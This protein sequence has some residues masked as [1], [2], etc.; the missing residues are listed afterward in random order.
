MRVFEQIWQKIGF[1]RA[2]FSVY[3]QDRGFW[4]YTGKI[5]IKLLCRLG[6][7]DYY[8]YFKRGNMTALTKSERVKSFKGFQKSNHSQSFQWFVYI[9]TFLYLCW[10]M[11]LNFNFQRT[12]IKAKYN[13]LEYIII[14]CVKYFRIGSR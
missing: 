8:F 4:A 9:N 1:L 7:I 2:A 11:F 6:D 5:R 10:C 3:T 14:R 12:L 13:I